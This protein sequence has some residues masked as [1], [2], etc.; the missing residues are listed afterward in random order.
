MCRE[1]DKYEANQMAINNGLREANMGSILDYSSMPLS[2]FLK[3]LAKGNVDIS[4][5]CV[6]PSA[7]LPAA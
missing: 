4:A 5:A 2:E 6:R 3:E 7:D 1:L